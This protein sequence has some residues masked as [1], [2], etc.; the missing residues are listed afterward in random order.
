L[1]AL[2]Q[3]TGDELGASHGVESAMRFLPGLLMSAVAVFH[4][5]PPARTIRSEAV[6]VRAVISGGLVDIAALGRVHL[7]GIDVPA[8]G[9]RSR[10]AAP[11]GREARDRLASLVLNRWVRLEQEGEPGRG[12]T[13]RAAYVLTEEGTFVNAALVREGLARVSARRAGPR[14]AELQRAQAEARSSRRG[15][16]AR[17]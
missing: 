8:I 4:T 3:Q 11:F 14:L 13:R 10:G 7:L 6:L 12:R 5:S 1:E 9:G 15:L 16:W 17:P 2:L